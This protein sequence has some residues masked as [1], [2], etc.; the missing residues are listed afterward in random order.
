MTA[1]F[2]SHE[3][4]LIAIWSQKCAS[5]T[6]SYWFVK[7]VVGRGCPQQRQTDWLARHGC[8]ITYDE[9][10]LLAVDRGYR[11]VQFTRHSTSRA[12]SA[13]LN[14]FYVHKGR[15]LD[16]FDKLQS[17]AKALI[18]F[19]NRG[20]PHATTFEGISFDRFLST[21][22][23]MKRAKE[24]IDPHWDTQLPDSGFRIYV[25]A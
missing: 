8:R 9:A 22:R 12:I 7:A 19:S 4:K 25:S 21:V 24:V 15:S 10:R 20:R 14:K 16:S 2:V 3:R 18:K 6:V 11:S 17:M 23:E 1:A 5:S 13:Y